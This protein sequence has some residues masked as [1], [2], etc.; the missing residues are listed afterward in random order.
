MARKLFIDEDENRFVRGLTDTGAAILGEVFN[1]D[2]SPVSIHHLRRT[3]IAGRPYRSVDKSA[4]DLILALGQKKG[5][6]TGGDWTITWGGDTTASLA[7]NASAQAVQ[8]ALNALASI[9]SAGGVDVV[10]AAAASRY[11]ITFRSNGARALPTVE[12]S[13]LIPDSQANISTRITGTA[14]KQAVQ[15]I[16][17]DLDP[18]V[19][20]SDFTDLPTSVTATVTTPTGGSASASEVQK[21]A[22]DGPITGGS[23]SITIPS[24][25]RSVTAAV[26]AGVFTTTANHGF[27]I[28]EPV[29]PSGFSNVANFAN[30]TTYYVAAV[31]SPTTFTIAATSGGSAISTASADAGSGTIT[32]PAQTTAE[33]DGTAN[34]ATIQ[35]ALQALAVIGSGNLTVSGI[36]GEYLLLSF[37]GAKANANFP[38]VTVE[39][40]NLIPLY[41]KSCEF[42]I[43]TFGAQDLI[44]SATGDS[45]TLALEVETT[46]GSEVQT[47]QADCPL[48]ED[49]I[50]SGAAAPTPK[51]DALAGLM[52]FTA[53]S[54]SSAETIEFSKTLGAKIETLKVNVGSGGGSYTTGIEL[55]VAGFV[56]GEI[57]RIRL[58]MPASLNPTI[59]FYS[60]TTSPTEIYTG[61]VVGTG[62]AF[63]ILLSFTFNGTAWESD[64]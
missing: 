14:S 28:G 63:N 40:A 1:G 9:T 64:Q 57:I 10:K 41:G 51:P 56:A 34:F 25:T 37:T 52:T 24:D 44:D 60:G 16:S 33:I 53:I 4:A 8:D 58:A 61:G 50:K 36:V 48:T 15:V 18:A 42:D 23:F 12:D 47:T 29:T 35:T 30:G 21:I 22:W 45:V 59:R 55:D 11:R 43:S 2:N 38:A 54:T 20:Q 62:S 31:P 13:E 27:A 17:L 5:A 6:L 49:I 19:M 32:T 3:G 46:E 7:Y 39:D 26:V